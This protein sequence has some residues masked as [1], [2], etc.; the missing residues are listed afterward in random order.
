MQ[1][2]Y[3]F[4]EA[5]LKSRKIRSK[6]EEMDYC[7][8]AYMEYL[9]KYNATKKI[10]AVD[11]YVE[12]YVFQEN[13]YGFLIDSADGAGDVWMY[14]TIGPE[15]A[16]LVDTGFGIG[17]LKGL[18]D[19]LSGGKPLYVVNTHGHVDHSYGNCQFDKVY[20]HKLEVSALK[21]QNEHIWDYLFDEYGECKFLKFAHDDIVP[22]R[23][24][25]AV[26]C[27][28]GHIFDL[29]GGHEVELVWLPGHTQG[30]AAYLD[31][32]HH[33]LFTGDGTVSAGTGMRGG[34]NRKLPNVG[35]AC[36]EK[37]RDSLQKLVER[38]DQ[39]DF[40]YPAHSVTQVDSSC[41]KLLLDVGNEVLIDPEC[42]HWE[43]IRTRN[44][45]SKL[46]EKICRSRGYGPV[47]YRDGTIYFDPDAEPEK[48]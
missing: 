42:Y 47:T 18:C 29:G 23:E 27:E 10:Y 26:G 36:V 19:M 6:G 31:K 44:D 9:R 33:A 16:L 20:C 21:T 3:S 37:W 13:L 24:Y 34:I 2:K 28:D 5:P 38:I 15:K 12:V 30:H 22:W 17:N 7:A 41:L 46:S 45:G 8:A 40:V 4:E 48:K 39:I 11:P 35:Y 32:Y 25:E 14:L 1:T 43:Q